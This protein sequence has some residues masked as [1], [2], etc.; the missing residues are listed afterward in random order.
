MLL[1]SGSEYQKAG[2]EISSPGLSG[3]LH[4]MVKRLYLLCHTFL[5]EY[6]V[7][8]Q[9]MPRYEHI[10]NLTFL[11]PHNTKSLKVAVTLIWNA[12]GISLALFS[13]Q[14]H[15]MTQIGVLGIC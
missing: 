11:A 8:V 5:F 3:E 7:A 9:K 2:V 10:Q 14:F 15:H 12:A 13:M 6:R 4:G 1:Y